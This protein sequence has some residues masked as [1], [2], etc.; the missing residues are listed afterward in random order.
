MVGVHVNW[1]IERGTGAGGIGMSGLGI[2]R[3]VKLVSFRKAPLNRSFSGLPLLPSRAKCLDEMIMLSSSM[4]G[5]TSR[6]GV[7]TVTATALECEFLM[8]ILPSE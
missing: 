3:Y 5:D 6:S 2:C 4:F 8:S 7:F 1:T